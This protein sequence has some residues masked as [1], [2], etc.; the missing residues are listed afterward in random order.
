MGKDD[1]ISTLLFSNL[2]VQRHP[3]TA[4]LK[5]IPSKS[6]ATE[7]WSVQ[8]YNLFKDCKVTTLLQKNSYKKLRNMFP[9][10]PMEVSK[11]LYRIYV[12]YIVIHRV[13]SNKKIHRG[14]LFVSECCHTATGGQRMLI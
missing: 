11:Q 8:R 7:L 13:A 4:L 9:P 3:H 5:P 14:G 12:A 6:G 10:F 2:E 1:Q